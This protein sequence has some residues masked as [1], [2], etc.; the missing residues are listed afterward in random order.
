[1]IAI[2][3]DIHGNLEALEAVL[4]DV[5]KQGVSDIYCLGDLVGYGPD[6]LPCIELA[7][8]WRIVLQ[9]NFDKASL[10]ADDLPGFAGARR[11]R[12]TILRFREQLELHPNRKAIQ[13][14]THVSSTDFA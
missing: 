1:M 4:S 11:A 3:S 13:Q 12:K 10:V 2:I 14:F 5:G 9:G 7:M 6:P 8:S